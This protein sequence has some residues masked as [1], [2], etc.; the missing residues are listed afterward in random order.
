MDLINFIETK[1]NQYAQK[2]V[3]S[4]DKSDELAFGQISVYLSLRRVL[5]GQGTMQDLGMIDA[6]ND[7]LQE[8]GIIE[9]GKTFYK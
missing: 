4:G 9:T 6:I 2:I 7:T 3:S 8:L 1:L 5:K